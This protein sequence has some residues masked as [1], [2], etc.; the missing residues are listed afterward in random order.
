MIKAGAFHYF[1]GLKKRLSDMNNFTQRAITG[2]GLIMVIL[3]LTQMGAYSFI[4]M[5]LSINLG[6]LMEFY[7]L[8][9]L[10]RLARGLGMVL[11]S[12]LILGITLLINGLLQWEMLL[13]HL[14]I[15]FLI[16]LSELYTRHLRPFQNIAYTF[17]GVICISL[18]LCCFAALA[19]LPFEKGY[20]PQLITSY[21][22]MI[23]AGDTGAYLAGK[24]FGRT[25]LF[26]RISPHKTWE[27]AICGV[28]CTMLTAVLLSSYFSI[29]NLKTWMVWSVITAITDIFGDLFKSML[30][31][32]Y[33]VKDTGKILPGHGG[34]LDRFDALLGSA[35]F[36]FS[37]LLLYAQFKN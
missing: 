12:S 22:F 17:T 14:L 18:P 10:T 28:I 30:K 36:A 2:L 5:I 29:L 24:Y 3:F 16:L 9:S 34:I 25:L 1:Y 6:A 15:A 27:G 7:R 31:R 26:K 4:A 23:W 37:Y 32:S 19:F 35:P 8:V 33:H 21:F 11:G 20:H 13:V